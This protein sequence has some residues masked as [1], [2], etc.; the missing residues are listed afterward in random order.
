MLS[1]STVLLVP[2]HLKLLPFHLPPSCSQVF[3]ASNMC[4]LKTVYGQAMAALLKNLD[5]FTITA[6]MAQVLPVLHGRSYLDIA[7]M[8]CQEEPGGSQ[9]E[10]GEWWELGLAQMPLQWWLGVHQCLGTFVSISTSWLLSHRHT[11]THQS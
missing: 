9:R 4:Q 11:D 1:S 7:S 8:R 5:A 10:A 6:T 3:I 2:T